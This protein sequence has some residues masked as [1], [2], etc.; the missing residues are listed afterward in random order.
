MDNKI[1]FSLLLLT[2]TGICHESLL[3]GELR[4]QCLQTVSGL[5]SPK[6]L[7]HVEIIPKG[8]QCSTVEVIAKL[9]T[10]QQICLDP[11]AK[12]VKMIINRIL[13]SSSGRPH[14]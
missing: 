7:V 4:C 5:V 8:P 14:K 13:R 1:T 11:Q 10:S 2:L 3:G 9:K 6:L 12:W